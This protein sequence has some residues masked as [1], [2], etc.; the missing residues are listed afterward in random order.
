MGERMRSA[1]RGR[2]AFV[3]CA[4]AGLLPVMLSA[5]AAPSPGQ[6]AFSSTRDDGITSEI[7]VMNDD[8]TDQRRLTWNAADDGSP[9]WSPD[10]S[11]MVFVSTRDGDT[12]I[13]VMGVDGSGQVQLT[14]H[15]GYDLDPTWSPDGT[16][17]AYVS[18]EGDRWDIYIMAADGSS[19]VR[20]SNLR[21]PVGSPAWSPDGTKMAFASDQEG[22]RVA[23]VGRLGAPLGA[24]SLLVVG[25]SPAW[26]PDGSHIAYSA[27]SEEGVGTHGPPDTNVDLYVVAADGGVPRRLTYEKGYDGHP[28]F[29][30]DGARLAFASNRDGGWG[31]YAMS[32]DGGSVDR[33]TDHGMEPAWS[34][35]VPSG[36]TPVRPTGWGMLKGL[37]RVM[38]Q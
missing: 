21:G 16:R 27:I 34:W 1:S 6:I 26:S 2:L 11:R 23:E 37:V 36:D 35:S 4:A 22:I 38:G 25:A 24:T 28:S 9:A 10:G 19:P 12:E 20:W 5:S 31:V 32:L 29:S 13:Y 33:L 8:G 15:P 14:H 17:I 3:V 30:P 18:V 7:Y